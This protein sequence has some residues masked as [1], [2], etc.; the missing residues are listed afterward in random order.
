M[1]QRESHQRSRVGAAGTGKG[2]AYPRRIGV[3]GGRQAGPRV[4]IIPIGEH[5]MLVFLVQLVVLVTVARLLGAAMKR[6]GQPAVVGHLAAGLVLGPSVFGKLWPQGARWVFPPDEVQSGML[7]VVGLIGIVML[8][9]VTGFETDL[10]LIRRLG[11]AAFAVAGA[12][13]AIPFALGLATGYL[14]PGSFVPNDKGRI[15]FALFMAAALSISSLPVIAKILSELGLTRR[16][17]GQVILAAGMGN[18][19]IGWLALGAIASMARSGSIELG[20]LAFTV[21]GMALFLGLAFMVGGPVIDRLL[22]RV[23]QRGGGVEGA[24]GVTLLVAFAAGTV[25]QALGVE[26]VLGAFVAGILLGRSKFQDSNVLHTLESATGAVFAPLFFATAG[27]RVDVA[28]LA[29]GDVLAW[30]V[31]VIAVATVGKL[32]GAYLGGW[33]ARLP[34]RE[35]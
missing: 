14:L 8:L 35:R 32:V 4:K 18:D 28:L 33:L 30:A 9:V 22:R 10:A 29:R 20:R 23:R 26:A 11:R 21:V 19:V 5:H 17:F 15:V 31:V 16:N 34:S 27:L 3:R 2:R 7:L 6:A 13:V 25:T 24:L 12:S 1:V